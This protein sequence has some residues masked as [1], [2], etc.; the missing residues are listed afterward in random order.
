ML[1]ADFQGGFSSIGVTILAELAARGAQVIALTPSLSSTLVLELIPVLRSTHG[2]ELIFAEECDLSSATSIKAFCAQFLRTAPMAGL[3]D[4]PNDAPRIDAIICAHEYM[5]IGAFGASTKEKL[6]ERAARE[7]GLQATFYLTTQLLPCLLRALPERDIR[8]INVINPLYAA[9]I[10]AFEPLSASPPA[11]VASLWASEGY[12][13]LRAMIFARHLQRVLDA[14]KERP[15]IVPAANAEVN[16]TVLE[17]KEAVSNILSVT[18]CPGFTR[19]STVAPFLRADRTLASF[20]IVGF[21]M[22]A[23]LVCIFRCA[24]D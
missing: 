20:S 4:G 19:S 7:R 21:L 16:T 2:N 6:H 3:T 10:P 22:Y 18:V 5:H 24:S 23:T 14:L 12:R 11:P 8:I 9:A 1:G 15:S 13:A 17:K